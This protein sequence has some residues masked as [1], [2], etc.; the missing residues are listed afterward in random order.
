MSDSPLPPTIGTQ[1]PAESQSFASFWQGSA[2]ELRW[3]EESLRDDQGQEANDNPTAGGP[4]VNPLEDLQDEPPAEEEFL[5]LFVDD[6][7]LTLDDLTTMLLVLE[8]GG[9]RDEIEKLV[10]IF[11]RIKGSAAMVGLKRAAKL[12]HC[13]ENV[14]QSLLE[15]GASSAAS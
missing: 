8:G 15:S 5:T 14:L 11:H 6:T 1:A 9:G 13:L 12:A 3:L 7:L 10:A 2:E 4:W